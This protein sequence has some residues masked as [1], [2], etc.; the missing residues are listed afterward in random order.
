MSNEKLKEDHFKK[1]C[2]ELIDTAVVAIREEVIKNSG[3]EIK[4]LQTSV[5]SLQIQVAVVE[6]KM[7]ES[8]KTQSKI[9]KAIMSLTEKFGKLKTTQA[10]SGVKISIWGAAG[11][12]LPCI[13]TALFILLRFGG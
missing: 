6:T 9:E 3:G 7:D 11:A 12:A 8:Q 13:V 2:S 1:F 4:G 10:V 5:Q